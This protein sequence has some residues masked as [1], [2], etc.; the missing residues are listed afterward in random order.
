MERF[1]QIIATHDY[2]VQQAQEHG[3][4]LSAMLVSN[5]SIMTPSMIAQLQAR[6]I[7][8][9][10]FLDGIGSVHDQQ[11]PFQG[12]PVDL[13]ALADRSSSRLLAHGPQPSINVP[14]SRQNRVN[15]SALCRRRDDPGDA[16]C[17]CLARTGSTPA[18][19]Y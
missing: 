13:F 12:G 3:I 9:I 5:A 14:V 8:L 7:H 1:P 10:I 4:V 11:R 6:H 19:D 15:R 2:A 16:R 17:L 18:A